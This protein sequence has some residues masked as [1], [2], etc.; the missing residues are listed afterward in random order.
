MRFKKPNFWDSKN[1]SLWAILLLPISTIYLIVFFLIK[2][3]KINFNQKHYTIPII[4]VGNIVVGG[5]G[6]TPL[7]IEIFKF[8][9]LDG[10]KPAFIK[11]KYDY[12]IDEVEMLKKVGSTFVSGKNRKIAINN[13]ISNGHNVVILDDGY[14]DFS[15]KPNFSVLCFNSK[16]LIGNGLLIPSGPMRE[17][18]NT[19]SRANCIVINGK[20]NLEFE[21]KILAKIDK[22]KI[23]IFYF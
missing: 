2:F 14:Q 22:K 9:K 10:K 5:T 23:P 16:Q 4:C 18:L 6:K 19:I 17:K 8:L 12:L 15:L 21:N 13:S 1:I 7:T 20:K 11:K 3:Y